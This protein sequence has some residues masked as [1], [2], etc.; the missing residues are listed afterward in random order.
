MSIPAL[1]AIRYPPEL[2][3]SQRKDDIAAAI[4]DH[5][6]VVVAG[7]T[8]SGK[9]TQLPKICLELGRARDGRVIGHTQPRRVAAR[10]VAERIASELGTELGDFV[11]YKIRFTDRSSDHTAVK[12]M[13][14]GILLAEIQR[15]RD[16][17]AYDTIII[18]EAHE[19]SLNIDFLLG[20]LTRLLPRR[21]D[22][23]VVITSAT[24]DPQRFADHF[25][26]APVIEVSGRMYP[27]EVR[28]RD[29]V[30]DQTQAIV[31]AVGELL[32]EGSGDILT[33][34]SGEREIR[35]AA[36]A[37]RALQRRLKREEI[38]VL[39][40][41][42]RLSAAEQHRVFAPHARRR[43]ILATN[44]AETSLTVPGVHYVVDTGL[45]RVSRFSARTKVQ[46]LPIEPISKASA[47]QRKGR[48]G[49]VAA[50]VCVR[51][52]SEEDYESRPAF[53]EPEILRTSLASVILQMAA[54]GLGDIARFPFVEAPDTRSIQAGMQLL[55]EIGAVQPRGH[56]EPVRLTRVGRQLARVPVDPRL[57]R[58][59]VEA[60]RLECL[61]E[62]IVI[63]AALSIQDPRER[64]ADQQEAADRSHARFADKSSDFASLLNLWEYVQE[65]QR[66]LSSGQFR[67]M[68]RADFLNFLRIR[69][70]QDL[71]S[72]LRQI[73]RQLGLR[74][75]KSPAA[76]ESI[77]RAL[78]AGLL[79]HIG[80][81]DR[82]RRDY[83]GARGTRFAVFP[84]SALFKKQPDYLMSAELVET[85]RLWA[86]VNAAIDPAWAEAAGEPLL[87]RTYSEPHWEKRRAGVV[88][89][90]RVTLYGVPLAVGRRVDYGRIDPEAAREL[91]I[92]S[93]LVERDW[94]TR[95]RFL[96]RNAELL[97]EADL[98]ERRARRR[99][100]VVDDETLFEFYDERIPA[101]VVSGAHFD[102]WWKRQRRETPDLL[103]F[104][105]D[106][107]LRDSAS[108]VSTADYPDV[109]RSDGADLP[110]SYEFDPGSRSDGVTVE[111]PVDA[112]TQLA[113]Q[114]FSWPVPGLRHDL[115]TALLR[116]LPKSIRVSFVPAPD[117]AR[118]FLDTVT[119]GE[120]PLL[121]ALERYLRK[122]SGVVITRSDWDLD[123]VPDHLRTTFRVHDD[124][125][126]ILAEGKDLSDLQGRLR[127]AT[128][129]AV[130]SAASELER[131]GV[132]E[133]DF[134]TLPREYPLTRAGR[135]VRGYPAIV[136]EGDH[137]AIRVL[138]NESAQQSSMRR[139][140]RRLLA[141]SSASPAPRIV[142][143]MTNEER[144]SLSLGQPNVPAFLDDCWDA[145][146]DAVV[147]ASGA[148][149]WDRESF[150]A[151]RERLSAVGEPALREVIALARAALVDGHAVDRRLAGRADLA[152][153]PALSDMKAQRSRLIYPGFAA[154]AG[155][156][157]LGRYP[158]YFAAMSRR[159]DALPGDPR[160]DADLM[161]AIAPL[162]AAYLDRVAALP[163]G[164]PP[165][166]A[167]TRV[168]W[169]LEELRLSLWAQ[170]L[171]TAEP[172]SPQRVA[173]ALAEV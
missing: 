107:L 21:R 73:A 40:L 128:E 14:D 59:M 55:E 89:F 54:L 115:V 112:L 28:Y 122:V 15:D 166:D 126:Q 129:A 31:D 46:R 93:A 110:L 71:D 26:G 33:F 134:E 24:I 23:K 158:R 167:L 74:L 65:Q 162:Q 35:D 11:G 101:D 53:T 114:D 143:S 45:A 138:A 153:L 147:R 171:K 62:V 149:P 91:F 10:T 127:V 168:R 144:L 160:R 43:V 140:V 108:T 154:D 98:L 36:D 30:D 146:I 52:Y 51:L 111:I 58:M 3:V 72:Q 165:S 96:A 102:A 84:G 19:R 169:L 145:A 113:E 4:R 86:R 170:D 57:G 48:C 94:D 22:L 2:P 123:K 41:Y 173:R 37:L 92:R 157:R 60:D 29:L 103:T 42:A 142:D 38:E 76:S 64:P 118:D 81:R 69:E 139:G 32:S 67:R 50:G 5:Q 152:L 70:W 68:C 1:G 13:T 119:P 161:A 97:E 88:A 39:P 159:L 63:V 80:E 17:R 83:L 164:Q 135:D 7:E 106:M 151:V 172:V 124:S 100:I 6:V 99:D 79:S 77:H 82:E 116:S 95:H 131:S 133:W 75:N 66:A 141:L 8:G 85:G 47:D 34:L 18:D 148:L 130:S 49:R 25:G 87:K 9:T 117:Y 163:T 90:E 137:V 132:V 125:G 150:D 120:E 44:V 27:V 136:D 104:D 78:L 156:D 155:R 105:V 12:V 121:D 61:R 20:Y 109:W 16:L 56:G